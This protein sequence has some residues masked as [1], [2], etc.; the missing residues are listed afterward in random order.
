M[1]FVF[2]AEKRTQVDA[3][4]CVSPVFSILWAVLRLSL[5]TSEPHAELNTGEPEST[6]D[7]S[8]ASWVPVTLGDLAQV[9]PSL[10]S[11]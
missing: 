3:K 1:K 9:L 4:K 5:P 2:Q 6:W 11:E 8:W 7:A 10:L